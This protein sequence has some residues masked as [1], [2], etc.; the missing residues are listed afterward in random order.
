MKPLFYSLL[1]IP[2]L[3][4][5]CNSGARPSRAMTPQ[6]VAQDK[7]LGGLD[8][9]LSRYTRGEQ[10]SVQDV[11]DAL[12]YPQEYIPADMGYTRYWWQTTW[13]VRLR[14]SY[15]LVTAD[16][17]QDS[18]FV[19]SLTLMKIHDA[20]ATARTIVE[21]WVENADESTDLTVD[22][23]R[24]VLGPELHVGYSDVT[25]GGSF[26]WKLEG[27]EF[28]MSDFSVRALFSCWMGSNV[29]THTSGGTGGRT[30][31]WNRGRPRSRT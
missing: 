1:V 12:G 21:G 18:G 27:D 24:A 7:Y 3:L 16:V 13:D 2:L 9:L 15:V 11:K 28:F 17:H 10:L 31:K 5:G 14:H 22:D 6:E 4:A 8:K 25:G 26:Y 23:V 19:S 30:G 29:F 20:P